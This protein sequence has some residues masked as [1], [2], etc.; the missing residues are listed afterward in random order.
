MNKGSNNSAS[1]LNINLIIDFLSVIFLNQKTISYLKKDNAFKKGVRELISYCEFIENK[2]NL[3]ESKSSEFAAA[4]KKITSETF[5]KVNVSKFDNDDIEDKINYIKTLLLNSYGLE[6]ET[7]IKDFNQKPNIVDKQEKEQIEVVDAN[8]IDESESTNANFRQDNP[9]P[10]HDSEDFLR[11]NN[12]SLDQLADN[13]MKQQATML[14]N[15]DIAENK[16]YQFD[17]KPKIFKITKYV[18]YSFWILFFLFFITLLILGFV[19]GGKV[20]ALK[21]LVAFNAVDPAN[22][23]FGYLYNNG[24]FFFLSKSISVYLGVVLLVVSLLFVSSYVYK[25]IKNFKNDNIQYGFRSYFSWFIIFI[26]FIQLLFPLFLNTNSH[27]FTI[28]DKLVECSNFKFEVEITPLP[29]YDNI[30]KLTFDNPSIFRLFQAYYVMNILI[31]SIAG[32]ILLITV[33]LMVIKPKLDTARINAK[34]EEYYN[35]IKSGRIKIDQNDLGST[36]IGGF[37]GGGRP[38]SPF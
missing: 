2:Q 28:Y 25:E 22:N 14:L 21:D 32:L 33:S 15:K 8:K 37:F 24:F 16:F 18:L 6:W 12:I 20:Y 38:F 30:S 29:Q 11:Q 1:N 10:Y 19:S 13:L 36:G 7:I 17:S 3:E 31:L 27:I 35:D 34:I 9:H 4:Y 23:N 5:K 26:T